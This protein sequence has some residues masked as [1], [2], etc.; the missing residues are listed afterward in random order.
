MKNNI[1]Q[2]QLK[3]TQKYSEAK[4]DIETDI[5][6]SMVY[7]FPKGTVTAKKKRLLW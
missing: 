1:E 6:E 3:M 2:L 7:T 5:I 4:K